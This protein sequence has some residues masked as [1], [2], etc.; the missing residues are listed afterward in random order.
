MLILKTKL[1]FQTC[2]NMSGESYANFLPTIAL[3][4][5]VKLFALYYT[6]GLVCR[7]AYPVFLSPL[8]SIPGPPIA[9]ITQW[10]QIYWNIWRGG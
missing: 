9:A 8:R 1:C 4:A 3:F 10:Y 2:N 7:A 5:F 6:I